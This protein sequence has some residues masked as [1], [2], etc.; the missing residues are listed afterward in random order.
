MRETSPFT[1]VKTTAT[2]NKVYHQ[3]RCGVEI[4]AFGPYAEAY[5]QMEA[6]MKILITGNLN[7]DYATAN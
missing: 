6:G 7:I 4:W 5:G 2:P 1:I 3:L